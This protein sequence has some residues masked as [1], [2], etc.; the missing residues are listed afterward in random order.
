MNKP[1]QRQR[2]LDR[3]KKGSLS[4]YDATYEMGIKQAPTRIKELK[5]MGYVIFSL[6]Q[7]DRSVIWSLVR[8]PE[9][10]RPF[11]ME[12]DTKNNIARKVYTDE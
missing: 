9:K 1:T 4:S 3:L 5:D 7:K 8:G 11:R 6:R 12:F 10:E 2:I